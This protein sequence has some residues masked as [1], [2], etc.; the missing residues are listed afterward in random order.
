LSGV[1]IAGTSSDAGK[2]L[3]V[4]G[5][6]RALARRGLRVAPY[7][8]QNMSNNSMVVLD[9][10]GYAEI[11]RAQWLQAQAARVEA[12]SAMNPVLLKPSTDRRSHVVLRGRPGGTLEAGEYATGRR[13]L[14]ETAFAAYAEL[15]PAYDLIVCEGAGS[16][17]EINLRDGDYVN[18]GLAERFDLPVVVVGDIDRGGILAALYGTWALVDEADR[19]RLRGYL[20]NKFRGDVSVLEPG[21][22]ELT[23][24][25]GMRS[26]GVLPWL[27][28]VWLDGEDAL[29]VDRWNDRAEY[30]PGTLSVAVIRLPR[31]SNSTDV[32]PLAAEPGVEVTVT[33]S[34]M[35]VATA[36]LV[37][38]PG[39]RATVSDLAWLRER[40]LAEALMA[41]V[42]AGRPVLG[43]CGGFQMLCGEIT[44]DV[45]SGRGTVA[46]LG[47]VPGRAEFGEEKV[48]GLP[49][50]TWQGHSVSGYEIHHGRVDARGEPFLDGVRAGSVW[51][52][53][54]HGALENDEFRRAWL[55]HIAA[56]AGS[57]WRPGDRAPGFVQRREAMLDRLGD[58]VAARID[59]A[60]LLSDA[61]PADH[62]IGKLTRWTDSGAYW[63]VVSRL[64]DHVTIAL[65]PCTG[66]EVVDRLTS[67]DP[68]LL[69]WLGSRSSSEDPA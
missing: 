64:P 44:D 37:V 6:C 28:D 54:W 23:R 49:T 14:A 35:T 4:A 10:D 47:L 46:G 1:L 30:A 40:G 27:E 8:A 9:P 24:R 41:R 56:Q 58:A 68:G 5:I 55:A 12:T 48:L 17:A 69:A 32:D 51:G 45:E 52:T 36:D 43:I 25:T 65:L 19:S 34:P 53:M 50:G 59:L 20:I 57:P 42:R 66:D 21:L 31:V 13:G 2:S 18:L 15:T 62:P 60:S 33:T 3:V 67:S 29:R 61:A 22:A 7:K 26:L 16:P 63:R 39:S 11:G 38:L